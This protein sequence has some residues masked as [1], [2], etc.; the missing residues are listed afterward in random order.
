MTILKVR[1]CKITNSGGDSIA[2]GRHF[3]LDD[4][5]LELSGL[6]ADTNY[7]DS[8]QDGASYQETFLGVR[9]LPIPFFIMKSSNSPEWIEQKRQEA[10]RV[11][12]P[13]KNPMRIDFETAAGRKY[14]LNGELV[15]TPVFA[16][17]SDFEENNDF[18]L[19]G[20]IQMTCHDPYIYQNDV[21]FVSIASLVPALEFP[22]VIPPEEGVA[23]G[24]RSTSLIANVFNGGQVDSGM[25]I[26]YRA[27]TSVLNPKLVNVNT[28]EELKLDFEMQGGDVVELSTE[29]G[30]RYARLIRNNETTSIFGRITIDSSFL[31]LDPGDNLFRYDAESGL[32][33]LDV[34]IHFRNKFVG[35]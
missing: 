7:S 35:V 9:E 28:Q 32:E 13:K 19:N 20:L 1:T 8:N 34:S 3:F 29:K 16:S 27:T 5:E 12:N 24:Y 2:F 17:K 11:L 10:F 18:W 22:I 25:V 30:N 31:Q 14:Y 15:S 33:N 21:T 26:R 23:F 4:D 6:S